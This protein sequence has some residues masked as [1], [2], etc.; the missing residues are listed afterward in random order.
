MTPPKP[1]TSELSILSVL[2]KQGP[3]TVREVHTALSVEQEMGYTT[4]LKF[5]QIM[6]KKGLV[7][8][9]SSS[10]AHVYD[11]VYGKTDVQQGLVKNLMDGVF[12]GSVKSL[13]LS[14]LSIDT[15]TPE[16]LEEIKSIIEK[17]ER[18]S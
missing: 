15:S 11:S 7:T 5:L 16:E 1:T 2:W 18:K 4:V 3:S 9:D 17:M 8:R 12:E 13:M 14:A 10:M 6:Y